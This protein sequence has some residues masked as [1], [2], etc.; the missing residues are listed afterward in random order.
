MKLTKAQTDR[1]NDTS[2][3]H[4]KR[5]REFYDRAMTKLRKAI[6]GMKYL[7]DA[8]GVDVDKLEQLTGP[9]EPAKSSEALIWTRLE[10]AYKELH[11]CDG[12]DHDD[13]YGGPPYVIDDLD[14]VFSEEV[15]LI[16][17][18]WLTYEG[19]AGYSLHPDNERACVLR[20]ALDNIQAKLD[21]RERFT[22]L[23]G[24]DPLNGAE[25]M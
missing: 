1:L 15:D 17:G 24:Y 12:F 2:K 22:R 10:W 3:T 21:A 4:S 13:P 11:Q 20:S 18:A 7:K 14:S 9:V 25:I 19:R 16:R 23:F 6:A 5:Y 8:H